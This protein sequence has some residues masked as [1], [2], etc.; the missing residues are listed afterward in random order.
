[1]VVALNFMK[2]PVK[3][4]ILAGDVSDKATQSMLSA[5]HSMYLPNKILLLADGGKGQEF[6][7]GHLELFKTLSRIGNKT[8]AYVCEDYVCKLPTTD[9]KKF[10]ELLD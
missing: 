5:V 4:I 8:T 10:K 9:H 1:M 3:Q 7:S 6:L 2:R